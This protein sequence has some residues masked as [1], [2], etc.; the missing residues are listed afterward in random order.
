MHI[1]FIMFLSNPESILLFKS[2]AVLLYLAN[3][4]FFLLLDQLLEALLLF[5]VARHD[6]DK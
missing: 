4:F 5:F 2:V 3:A 6:T 1:R